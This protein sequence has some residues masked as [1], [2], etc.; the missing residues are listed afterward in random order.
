MNQAQAHLHNLI[1]L[2]LKWL[3]NKHIQ[4]DSSLKET[5]SI[6]V[7]TIQLVVYKT[8]SRFCRETSMVG[9]AAA[10]A[11][12]NTYVAALAVA[13]GISLGPNGEIVTKLCLAVCMPIFATLSRN[14]WSSITIWSLR[15]WPANTEPTAHTTTPQPAASDLGGLG[16]F[17]SLGVSGKFSHNRRVEEW[18]FFS[19]KGKEHL[20]WQLQITW[21]TWCTTHSWWN[22]FFFL[23]CQT[24]KNRLLLPNSLRP[25]F[26]KPERKQAQYWESAF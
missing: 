9:A 20:K 13:V 7:D 26:S 4:F 16:L 21:N 8:A 2:W 1:E 19:I 12:R 5:Y 23:G 11:R 15:H 10:S 25:Y 6:W 24:R 3:N 14:I 17:W 18:I 22:L